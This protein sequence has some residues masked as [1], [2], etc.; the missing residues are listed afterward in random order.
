MPSQRTTTVFGSFGA[1]PPADTGVRLWHAG[2]C[3]I[4]AFVPCAAS[5][6]APNA[7]SS[8][9]TTPSVTKRTPCELGVGDWDVECRSWELVVSI[10]DIELFRRG[11][12]AH[13]RTQQRRNRLR[14][15]KLVSNRE[16]QWSHRHVE[17]P[18]AVAVVMRRQHHGRLEEPD[19]FHRDA[20]T[21]LAAV[22]RDEARNDVV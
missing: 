22:V 16:V 13:R 18:V 20:N 8:S 21:R 11:V 17:H 19:V 6:E 9:A 7:A 1:G 12:D 2:S 14:L 4:A 3:C 10:P 15:R 5:E